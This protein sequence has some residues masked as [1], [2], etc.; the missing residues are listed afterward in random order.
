MATGHGPS[1]LAESPDC[2]TGIERLRFLT[3]G[4][5]RG[6]EIDMALLSVS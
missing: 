3:A 2:C 5:V 1:R 6:F 4:S